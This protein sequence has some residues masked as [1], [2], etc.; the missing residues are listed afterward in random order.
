MFRA[1][2]ICLARL[3]QLCRA[4]VRRL[5]GGARKPSS[6]DTICHPPINFRVYKELPYRINNNNNQHCIVDVIDVEENKATSTGI[7]EPLL[8]STRIRAPPP[9]QPPLTKAMKRARLGPYG[10]EQKILLV[11]EGDFSFSA[12]LAV[13]FGDASNMIA[14]S[15]DSLEFLMKNYAKAA[16]NIS[17]LT[18]KSCK[19][20]HGVDATRMAR[21]PKLRSLKFDIVVYNFPHAG[22][23][24]RNAS[25]QDQISKHQAL[26]KGFLK[27]A[28]KMIKEEDG[29]IHVTHKCSSFFLEWNLE[30]LGS[31]QG[32]RLVE[33]S[34]FKRGRYPGYATKY[35]FGG[36]A[37]FNCVPSKTYKFQLPSNKTSAGK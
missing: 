18:T 24:N 16:T 12:S 37:N 13:A 11:G 25:R 32:L 15:L 27:N 3:W 33:E 10:W 28:K 4:I 23:A 21:H 20:I 9:P 5:L 36:D 30:I 17:E 26:V 19:V 6:P 8:Q 34:P 31:S 1:S 35:G 22:F 14:T 29:Q 2:S 7:E